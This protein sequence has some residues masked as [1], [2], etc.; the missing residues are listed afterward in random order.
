MTAV[1][2]LREVLQ[3]ALRTGTWF[4]FYLDHCGHLCAATG[5]QAE[6]VTL[7]A[8]RAALPPR[9]EDWPGDARRR[10]EPLRAA[11]QALGPAA[12]GTA[13]VGRARAANQGSMMRPARASKPDG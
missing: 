11:R 10:E 5:R 2:H 3:L 13:A 8:A 12:E 4:A 1:A 9:E 7:W 6:A